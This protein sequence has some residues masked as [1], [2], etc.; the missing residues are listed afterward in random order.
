MRAPTVVGVV[1]DFLFIVATILVVVARAIVRLTLA[2]VLLFLVFMVAL[3]GASLV[4]GAL[5]EWLG[6]PAETIRTGISWAML[7]GACGV[8][9]GVVVLG[10]RRF[11]FVRWALWVLGPPL[12][13]LATAH[14]G[15]P[16]ATRADPSSPANSTDQD[17]LR[18]SGRPIPWKRRMTGRRK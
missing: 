15:A 10:Y 18:L 12:T 3:F 8:T 1:W 9:L 2:F 17:V 7:A 6:K 16:I 11:A 14:S 13:G 4:G 5:V